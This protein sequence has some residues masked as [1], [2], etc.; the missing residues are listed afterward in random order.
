MQSQLQAAL[1]GQGGNTNVLGT[2][3]DEDKD[4]PDEEG[5]DVDEFVDEVL[6]CFVFVIK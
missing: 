3:E 6:F 4:E 5:D 1:L 2:T